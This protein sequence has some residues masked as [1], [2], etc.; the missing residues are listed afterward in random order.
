MANKPSVI[1]CERRGIWA[2]GLRRH[3]PR[4]IR[5]CETRL[6]ADCRRE[7]AGAPP[8][9]VVVELSESNLA[10]ALDLVADAVRRFPLARVVAVAERGWE[11]YE[12]LLR[13][14]GAI[15]FTTQPRKADTLARLAVRHVARVPL[16]RTTLVAE[17]WDSLPWHDT[18]VS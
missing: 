18:A 14:A 10:A 1:V 8:S 5:V 11:P 13:E 17:I 9:L 15:H 7:L 16:P 6:L 12:W 3:L 2:A 4:E